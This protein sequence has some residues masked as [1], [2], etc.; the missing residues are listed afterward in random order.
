MQQWTPSLIY[1]GIILVLAMTIGGGTEQGLWTDHL[2]QFLMLPA[3]YLGLARSNLSRVTSSA[4]LLALGILAVVL[5]QFAP[6]HRSA[7]LSE[8]LPS[9]GGFSFFS[10][11]PQRS[12][13]AALF[14]LSILGFTLFLSRFSDREQSQLLPFLFAGTCIN[15]IAGLVQLSSP[16]LP[17]TLDIL[18]YVPSVGLLANENHASSLIYIMIPMVAYR[19]LARSRQV[20]TYIG[21]CFVMVVFL[22][23]VGSRAGMA[24]SLA[25]AVLSLF[26]FL[27]TDKAFVLRAGL[28]AGGLVLLLLIP[29][30]IG[31]DDSSAK[32]LRPV[33]F[34]TTWKAIQ[35]HWLIGSGLGSFSLTYPAFEARDAILA[36]FINHAH[37]DYLEIF[38]EVGVAGVALIVVFFILIVRNFRRSLLA[39]ASALALLTLAIHTLVDYP[40]RTMTIGVNFAFF[41]AVVLSVKPNAQTETSDYIEGAGRKRTS[42]QSLP[43]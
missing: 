17:E 24:I 27:S 37:N 21:L 25:V 42:S 19:Y 8:I 40:L 29:F 6:V 34:A 3:L 22:F 39:E 36:V 38:L 13:E 14:T 18:P 43:M 5:I 26:W 33:I 30:F 20:W 1:A 4:K 12:L 11:V 35:S 9:S 16:R 32:E 15:M 41:V 28:F 23:A 31:F 2:L 10:P 7:E